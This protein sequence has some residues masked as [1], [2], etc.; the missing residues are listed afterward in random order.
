MIGRL[1]LACAGLIVLTVSGFGQGAA[2]EAVSI[3][4]NTSGE[5]R[6]S[7]G[8][9]GRTYTATNAPLRR[10]IAEALDLSF[11][12]DRL[13]GGPAWLVSDRFDILATIPEGAG[14]QWQQ[15]LQAMLAD[16]FH[17]A[18]HRETRDA[19]MFAL[20]L[21]RHDRRLGPRLRK[22]STD[23]TALRAAGMP[24]PTPAAGEEP[25]CSSQVDD[26]IRG[27]GQRIAT[28]ARMLTPFTGREVVDRTALSGEY[29]FDLKLP[30]ENSGRRP[31]APGLPAADA[32]AGGI[33]T[34]IQ[35]ELGLKLESIRA[36]AEF[37]VVDRVEH[38]A[39]D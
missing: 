26:G 8:T 29:D 20:V 38:P 35:D 3:K 15:M 12:Q 16:R 28:L 37:V 24:I 25:I 17:L 18:V 32:A 9:R 36:P 13:V 22:A 33:L 34:V 23:C 39:A 10:V 5:Q 21:V 30:E 4:R 2:F 19:P 6:M 11:E 7:I 31:G 27:R 14:S 1:G